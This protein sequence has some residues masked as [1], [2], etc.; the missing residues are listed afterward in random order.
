MKNGLAR[1]NPDADYAG[2]GD[3]DATTCLNPDSW[4]DSFS[5]ASQP[6][7]IVQKGN[8]KCSV[9]DEPAVN[10]DVENSGRNLCGKCGVDYQVAWRPEK[11]PQQ[12]DVCRFVMERR[13]TRAGA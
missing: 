12:P 2:A 4:N 10:I 3:K 6:K 8:N 1:H 11:S 13:I 5:V 7:E 9:C